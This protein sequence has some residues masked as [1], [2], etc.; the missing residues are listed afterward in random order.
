[1]AVICS[2]VADADPDQY[3]LSLGLQCLPRP[4][5]ANLNLGS[6]LDVNPK[7]SSSSSSPSSAQSGRCLNAV[8]YVLQ[9]TSSSVSLKIFKEFHKKNQFQV[10]YHFIHSR[11]IQIHKANIN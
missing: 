11:Y 10:M 9:N 5:N 8:G 4:V 3:D 7:P 1:M 2:E 6:L